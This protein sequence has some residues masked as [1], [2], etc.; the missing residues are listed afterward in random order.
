M[1]KHSS[2]EVIKPRPPA[3]ISDLIRKSDRIRNIPDERMTALKAFLDNEIP[4]LRSKSEAKMARI[5]R[6][7]TTLKGENPKSA[8][9]PGVSNVSV[10]LTM[11]V[12]SSVHKRLIRGIFGQRPFLAFDQ[13]AGDTDEIF[14]DTPI[15]QVLKSLAK[16][17]ENLILD[18]RALNGKATLRRVTADMTDT[19]L[20]NWIVRETPDILIQIPPD[21]AGD[22]G[23]SARDAQADVQFGTVRWEPIA[24]EHLLAYDNFGTDTRAMPLVGHRFRKTLNEIMLWA[25]PTHDHYDAKAVEEVIAFYE[26][27][28]QANLPPEKRDHWIDEIYTDFDITGKG[29]LA[30]IIV[31][32]HEG[33][34]KILRVAWNRLGGHRP[35]LL[36][37]FDTPAD[38]HALQGQGVCEK[39][40]S[41]QEEANILHNIAVESVKRSINLLV[42]RSDSALA[43]ELDGQPIIPS[44]AYATENIET[45]AKI[46]QLGQPRVGEVLL[47]FEAVNQQYATKLM[48]V[49]DSQ[50]GDVGSAKRVPAQLGVPIMREGQIFIEDPLE[51]VGT[52][53]VEGIYLTIDI[54]RRKPPLQAMK[55][56]LTDDEF[57][58][59]Q[60]T[61]FGGTAETRRQ[62]IRS[63]IGVTVKARDVAATQQ[64]RKN[65]LLMLSQVLT[66]YHDRLLQTIQVASAPDEQVPPATKKAMFHL[67]E[68]MGA[69]IEAFVRTMD[70][71]DDPAEVLADIDELRKLLGVSSVANAGTPQ[72]SAVP[73]VDDDDIESRGGGVV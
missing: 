37:Q 45:D 62:S 47:G 36:A 64:A 13:L 42:V 66:T 29:L 11:W 1:A 67:N 4:S 70:A 46:L 60:T 58:A 7:R 22:G 35:I 8:V 27:P 21:E 52:S 48:G 26:D 51:A 18:P 44:Q 25:N 6:W 20:G 9:T 2:H 19:G 53:M 28:K 43:E 14:G 72:L 24:F 65:E 57:T 31:D 17:M 71:I 15:K 49:G 5:K 41:P 12:R 54:M 59:L 33:V 73:V 34:Q 32:Y 68:K 38:P 63:S 50:L 56:I 23:D 69:S 3:G 40:E 10:P 61:V 16:L 55:N 39:L 30:P